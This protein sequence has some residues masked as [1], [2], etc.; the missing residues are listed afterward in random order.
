MYNKGVAHIILILIGVLVILVLLGF[1]SVQ[2][3]S[4]SEIDSS[5]VQ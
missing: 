1:F 4:D 3:G 2:Q 5:Q